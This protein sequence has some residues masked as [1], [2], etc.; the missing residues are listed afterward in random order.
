MP[1]NTAV[2]AGL[3]EWLTTAHA[4]FNLSA[5]SVSS[6]VF[7]SLLGPTI[8][9]SLYFVVSIAKKLTVFFT[10]NRDILDF[11]SFYA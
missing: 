1:E 9:T 8:F 11:D 2:M 7:L 6:Y 3:L 10:F 4:D 5:R